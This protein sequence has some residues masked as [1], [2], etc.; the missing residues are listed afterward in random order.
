MQLKAKL[1][2]FGKIHI[3]VTA[4]A[5]NADQVTKHATGFLLGPFVLKVGQS[6]HNFFLFFL[7]DNSVV[8]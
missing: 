5:S 3:T 2:R 7:K 6:R 8:R 1:F 4:D